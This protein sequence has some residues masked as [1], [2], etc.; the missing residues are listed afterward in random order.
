MRRA[1][2]H[3]PNEFGATGLRPP[4]PCGTGTPTYRRIHS[5]LRAC[6]QEV[7]AGLTFQPRRGLV[8][9]AGAPCADFNRR[10]GRA[11]LALI[12]ALLLALVLAAPASLPARAD[13][14]AP[15]LVYVSGTPA[16]ISVIDIASKQVTGSISVPGDPRG[17]VLS[18]DGRLLYTA[19]AAKNGVAV[20]D[21]HAQ[22]VMTT[23]PT[24]PGPTA[25]TLDLVDPL[26]LWVANT[27]GN[28]VTVLNAD[29]GKKLATIT[30]GQRPTSVAIA[31]PTSGISETDG[32][33]EVLV[34]N[35]DAKTISVIGSESFHM[36]ATVTM[37][38]A[39][40]WIS[41]SG[42][43]G[44]AY[45]STEQGHVYGL[46]LGSHQ[47]FGPLFSGQSFHLMDYDALSG[48]IYVPDSSANLLNVLRPAN[49]GLEPP[50]HF[51]AQPARPAYAIGG[52][53]WAVAITS[54]GALGMVAGHTSGNVTMLEIQGHKV[55][56]TI[57]VGGTPQA[58]LAG[59]YP[60][61][62]SQQNAQ[63]VLIVVYIVLGVL[64]LGAIG[65]LVVWLRRQE[66]RIRT[67][68]AQEDAEY[69][70]QL[71]AD[72][73]PQEEKESSRQE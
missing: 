39:P 11:L 67:L 37:T 72:E 22:Q 24:G 17:L 36:L 18:L 51:P 52:A 20:I 70:R 43:G 57:H 68:H 40:I 27:G 35:H 29:S 59:P 58:V 44:T 32:T 66:R 45:I 23:Y 64:L 33:S 50:A 47:L 15:N 25:L 2:S 3:S 42:V 9:P 28:S 14:G 60:P 69:E 62:V 19:L 73:A 7:P 10:C 41:V 54:D 53:P 56:T 49:S 21:A 5:A 65:W 48:D 26:H 55:I 46:T 1:T 61:L 16:G 34:A 38:E 12:L 30:T 4:S 31:L 8:A 63:I 71:R 13:G 6:G